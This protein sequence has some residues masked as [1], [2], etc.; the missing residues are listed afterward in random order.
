MRMSGVCGVGY[1]EDGREGGEEEEGRRRE[2]ERESPKSKNP[3]QRCGE[4]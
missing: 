1:H 2:K 4:Q 3:T